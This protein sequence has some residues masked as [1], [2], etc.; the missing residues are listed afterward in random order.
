VQLELLALA[1]DVL[2]V[3]GVM[4]LRMPSA[5]RLRRSKSIQAAQM[6]ALTVVCS[7]MKVALT[8]R[9]GLQMIV[10]DNSYHAF[11]LMPSGQNWISR[12]THGMSTFPSTGDVAAPASNVFELDEP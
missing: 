2:D 8:A 12:Q 3:Q 4:L 10:A 11:F 1:L 6:R 7:S 5:P 9:F